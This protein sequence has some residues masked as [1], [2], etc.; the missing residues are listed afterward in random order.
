MQCP[1]FG[2][3]IT[4]TSSQWYFLI[5]GVF[6]L[7][8]LKYDSISLIDNIPFNDF[9]YDFSVNVFMSILFAGTNYDT[10]SILGSKILKEFRFDFPVG[11][12]MIIFF[13]QIKYEIFK[14]VYCNKI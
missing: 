3:S 11:V 8:V 6:I 5:K 14:G 10:I 1:S 2:D 12:I 13:M 7:Q 4:V 9:S